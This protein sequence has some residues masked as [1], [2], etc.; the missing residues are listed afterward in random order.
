MKISNEGSSIAC[1]RSRMSRILKMK[2]LMSS[3]RWGLS[4]I[5]V[6]LI[7]TTAIWPL[8]SKTMAGF[9]LLEKIFHKDL[10]APNAPD[11]IPSISVD[12]V[13]VTEGDTSPVDAVFSVRLSE[14]YTQTVTVSYLTVDDTATAAT[15]DYLP[16][17]G[18]LIFDVGV[19]TLPITVTVQGDFIDEVDESFIISLTNPISATILDGTA[20]G[21]IT[22]NDVAGITVS[23]ISG[24]TTEGAGT[25][26]FTI[27]LDTEPTADVT[28][29]LSSSDPGEGTVSPGSVTFGAGDWSTAQTVTVTGV[30]D[31]VV[32]GNQGYTIVTAAATSTDSNY[33]GENAA[34]VSVTNIDDDV[35]GITVSAISGNTTEGAGTATFT[36]VLDTEPTADVTIGLSSSD[37]GEGTVSPGSVTFGAGD[38]STA[39][40]VTVTGVNDDIDDG[41]QVYSIV[42]AAATSTD[43]NYSGVNAADVSVTNTDDDTAGITVSA[44]SGNTTE[45]AGTATF[46]IVLDTEPTADVTIGLSSSDP[47]E[48]TVSPGSVTFGAGD[49]STAQTV[50]V[51][52]VNDDIDDGDQVYSIVTA[53][54]TSTDTNYS[55]ENAADVSVT[56][57][58]DDTAGITVS[59]ISGDTSETGA[60]ATF[61]IVLDTEPT[62]DVTIGL[63]SSDPGEG[64]VSPG[65]VTFGIGDWNLAQT[66]TVTGVDDDV[67]DG[68]QGYTIVTA[69]ATSTDSNYSGEN[70]ANISLT[71]TDDDVAGIT[72]NPTTGLV[73]SEGAGTATFTIVLDT[74][75]TA[76]VTIGLSSS[77]PGEGT[78]SPGSVTFGAGNWNTAQTVTVTG[79]NDDVDDGDQVYSI[80]TAAAT[81]TDSNYSGVNA[82][83]VSVTNTDDDGAGITVSAISG[84]TTEGAG[85]ATFT[86]VLDT[87]PTADV[88]IGLSSSDPGEGTVSPGSVTFGAGNWNTA[89]T[90]TVTGVNDDVDDGD[91]VYSIVTAAAT[92]TDSNYSGEDPVD[93]SVTNTDDDTAG[94]TVS[95][96]SG[97]TTEGAGTATFTIVLDTE[98]TADVTI[99]LSSSDPG[100]GTVSPGSVTFGAGDWSTAQ[101]VTVTGV[102]DDV[103]DGDQVY[104]IVTAAATSTDSNYSGVNAADVSVTN[105]DNDVAG[106]T[107][108]A[109]SGDTT[110]TGAQATFTI[111]LDTEPTADVT[112]GLSSSDPGEGTV[113]PGSVTFG[114][115]NWDIAQTVTVTG[116]NDDVDDGDQ[117][118]TIVTAAATS[119]DSN[120][121]GE[122]AANISLSNTDDDV[123]GVTISPITGLLTDESGSTDTFSAT[124]DSEPVANV[125]IYLNSTDTGEGVVSPGW[126]EFNSTNW[127]NPQLAVITGIDDV[128]I[129]GSQPYTIETFISSEDG[130]YISVDPTDLSVIN[131]DNDVAEITVDPVS[132]LSTTEAGGSDS[133]TMVLESQPIADVTV[134]V[135]VSDLSEG[136]VTPQTVIFTPSNWD[137]HQT[138]VVTGVD[139]TIDDGD[140]EYTIFTSPAISGDENYAGIDPSDV[141]VTNSNDDAAGIS[142]N[143]LLGLITTETGGMDSF[144]VVLDSQPISDVIIP[145][146]SSDETEGLVSPISLTFTSD[147]WDMPQ[148]VTITGVDDDIDDGDIAYIARTGTAI[149]SD[150][151]FSGKNAPDVSVTNTDDDTTPLAVSDEYFTNATDTN[152]LIVSAPG[153]LTND[154]DL[155]GDTISAVLMK[156]P[157]N[158]TLALNIDGSFVYTPSLMFNGI[159]IFSYLATDGTNHSS[160]VDVEIS[161]D[162]IPPTVTWNSPAN[163]TTLFI[164]DGTLLLVADAGDNTGIDKVRFRRWDAVNNVYVEIGVVSS[165]PYQVSLDI[166][167]LNYAFNEIFVD[168]Y[169][170]AGNVSERKHIWLYREAKINLP[171]IVR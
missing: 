72:V 170:L 117:G 169:D 107:V 81:S 95:A 124:L 53:A 162:L 37:P 161:V 20:I 78:V 28:I 147:D 21:T 52:G 8:T 112:I 144:T 66:V 36:I 19:A 14:T 106:I 109:I 158:G 65:S 80:V 111:V 99:G 98:P 67:V 40:T 84:N 9:S 17:S 50:T 110:E 171:L 45:G 120:Y 60:Q 47:G 149:S 10:L 12:D 101:T 89:Q 33:S 85:T 6:I 130:I 23:A 76:D 152:P 160:I 134:N 143:R 63:S 39:Q 159:A 48:G 74:E 108:S 145:L 137:I 140:I 141:A 166:S 119:T 96:I 164:S 32:D 58:D 43:S 2:Y 24:N 116:V 3:Y 142:L 102:N 93:V 88:T 122:N 128:V 90:V 151:N 29:G 44:I 123:A 126:L 148:V 154:I 62:A 13:I 38:W 127:D 26:T 46:T 131:T 113:S 165:E 64:T 105:T 15:G 42:T 167:T 27:V 79:V 51:T 49:W 91:Q 125:F 114:I 30:D 133:F 135:S 35:P 94:I 150:P 168:A 115:G 25:A 139:D 54:A 118:Y 69:A 82:A 156:D 61:T 73:T 86:I 41:N 7:L 83:D 87:E 132:G 138:I 163:N 146:G 59:A 18:T 4:G 57:T 34:D 11:A 157:Y 136:T 103:D 1:V 22:D 75:P 70:A 71:N 97:N 31:Q 68:D 5:F 16:A 77:D 153:V 155:D 121:S 129:D 55:G 92:S 100:E 56:N 104:S